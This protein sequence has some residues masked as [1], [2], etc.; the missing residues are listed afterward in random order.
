MT[1]YID[2]ITQRDCELPKQI[3]ADGKDKHGGITV[4]DCIKAGLSIRIKPAVKADD[5]MKLLGTTY[6]HDPGN[7][8]VAKAVKTQISLAEYDKQQADYEKAVQE[9][10]AAWEKAK[11]DKRKD[12]RDACGENKKLAGIIIELSE[13]SPWA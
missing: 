7:P 2:I 6:E 1:Q 13:R 3:I 5:G 4:E 11:E 12:I 9:A 10:Q 8:T